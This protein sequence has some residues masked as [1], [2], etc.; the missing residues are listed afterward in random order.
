MSACV[1]VSVCVVGSEEKRENIMGEREKVTEK[2]RGGGDRGK[3]LSF[4]ELRRDYL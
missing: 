1:F 2:M 3:S 4:W